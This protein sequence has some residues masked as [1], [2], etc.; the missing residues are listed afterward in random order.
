[1]SVAQGDRLAAAASEYFVPEGAR[2]PAGVGGFYS[3]DDVELA[4]WNLGHHFFDP[5]T[6]RWF[7]SRIGSDLYAGRFFVTSEQD[8]RPA[9]STGAWNGERRYSVRFARCD[10]SIETVGEF[11]AYGSRAAAHTAAERAGHLWR[12][13]AGGVS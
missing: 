12:I 7:G 6:K 9:A 5:A 3:V 8:R 2:F 13:R 4:N 1:M 11:G 10:G